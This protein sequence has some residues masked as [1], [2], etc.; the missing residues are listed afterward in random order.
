[1]EAGIIGLP[2]VG[3]TTLFAALTGKLDVKAGGADRA[4]LGMVDIP[5]GRL[6]VLAGLVT[7]RRVVPATMKLVDV[8]G[9]VPGSSTA[10]GVGGK[11]L[12]HVRTVDALIHVV[13]CFEHGA[14]THVEG[15]ID[16]V[17][18]LDAV[19]S[20]LLLH[21]L[22]II[23]SAMPRAVK[24]VQGGKEPEAA[25]RLAVLEKLAPVVGEG[26]PAWTLS[27]DDPEQNKALRG[28]GLLSTKKVLYVANVDDGDPRGEGPAARSVRDHARHT[29]MEAVALCAQLEREL[30]ELSEP[31]RVEMLAPLGLVEP[32]V[33]AVARAVYRLLDLQSFY[34]T[35]PKETRAWTIRAGATALEAA[36]AVHS[37]MKRGFIRAEVF[38][39]ADLEEFGDEKAIREAGRLRVEGK[40]YVMQPDDVAHILFNV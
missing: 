5:D 8:A 1:M 32:A 33:H 24:A 27:F 11:L 37:D 28:L 30:A 4:N 20:E 31:E 22:A 29:G 3:K 25:P 26:R 36:G 18:D 6:E 10:A 23:E 2:Y 12:D 35:N 38:S 39:V 34:T 13:R 7:S 21:D 40:S 9:L 16:P 14:V 17:R 15:S 19:E